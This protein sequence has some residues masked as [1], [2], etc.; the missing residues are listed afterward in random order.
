MKHKL[1]TTLVLTT[2]A[3]GC[4]HVINKCIITAST[5]KDLLPIHPG[6][7][8]DWRFGKV[9]YRKSGSGAPLLLVHDLD[10]A[11]SSYEWSQLEQK[12]AQNYTVYALDLP[13]CGRSDKPNLTYT[14]YL[15]VQL[16][17]EFTE[18]IIKKK[19]HVAATGI[20][21]SFAIMACNNNPDLFDKLFLIS[22]ESLKK[23]NQIPSKSSKMAKLL[24]DCPII[25]TFLYHVQKSKSNIEYDFTE[26][27]FSNPFKVQRRQVDI[28]HESSHRKESGGKYLYSSLRGNYVNINIGHALQKIDNSIFIV[29]GKDTENSSSILDSYV[30]LNPAI[31]TATIPNTKQLPQLEAPEEVYKLMRIFL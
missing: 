17:S 21:G 29:S 31:E 14:N 15:Y 19:T 28:Y 26:K 5:I 24:I 10:P 23:L 18:K 27:Y 2:M 1:K 30:E 12:L 8:F 13:G 16:I 7:Y 25:G 4:L 20:S 3:V 22:P 6:K 9:F 11:S